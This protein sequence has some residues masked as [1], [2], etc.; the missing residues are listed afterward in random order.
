VGE[1]GVA[2]GREA[3][4]SRK[5]EVIRFAG[6]NALVDGVVE[7]EEDSLKL[8]S[9]LLVCSLESGV[10][11]EEW[12]LQRDL[13]IERTDSVRAGVVRKFGR[14]EVRSCNYTAC[15]IKGDYGAKDVAPGEARP[16]E[17]RDPRPD[18]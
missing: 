9:W 14:E 15:C 3:D 6:V 18:T 11:H 7:C 13:E 2:F 1:G 10:A 12:L 17:R 4:G 16:E 8:K 5:P